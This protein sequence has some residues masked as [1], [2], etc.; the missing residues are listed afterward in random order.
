VAYKP[1][2]DDVRDSPALDIIHMLR[3]KG[4]LI[5]YSDPHVPCLSLDDVPLLSEDPYTGSSDA[6]CAVIITNHK[7]FDYEAIVERATIVV[8]TRNALKAFR[9]DKIVRL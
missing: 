4:A 7:A 1:D 2:I 9:S 5:S 6:D 3:A 8:D